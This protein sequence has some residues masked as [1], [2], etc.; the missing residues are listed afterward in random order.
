LSV[1]IAFIWAGTLGLSGQINGFSPKFEKK[2]ADM[3]RK[4][5]TEITQIVNEFGRISGRV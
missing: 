1:F 4:T 2:S 5:A 3:F